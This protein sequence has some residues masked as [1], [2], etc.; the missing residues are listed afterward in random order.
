MPCLQVSTIA[1]FD[2]GVVVVLM[3]MHPVAAASTIITTERKPITA[4]FFPLL[5]TR[6]ARKQSPTYSR[7]LRPG[8][9]QSLAIKL[10]PPGLLRLHGCSSQS[11]LRGLRVI[12]SASC[13]LVRGILQVLNKGHCSFLC[14]SL[15]VATERIKTLLA[16]LSGNLCGC[17]YPLG[18]PLQRRGEQDDLVYCKPLSLLIVCHLESSR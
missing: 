6:V 15:G 14:L 3:R 12:R 4:G 10:S 13:Q 5:A 11:G 16:C 8:M 18:H 9:A 2:G 1:N 17:P 7:G